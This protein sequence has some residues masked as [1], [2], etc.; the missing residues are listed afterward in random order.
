MIFGKKKVKNPPFP[1]YVVTN[2]EVD[3]KSESDENAQPKSAIAA[4]SKDIYSPLLF[5]FTS[6][7]IFYAETKDEKAVAR[8]KTKAKL[9]KV[10]K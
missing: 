7:S 2:E 9:A 6:P 1:T 8:D 4:I 10:R 5:Q 3:S